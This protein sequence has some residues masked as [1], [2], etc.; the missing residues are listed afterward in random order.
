MNDTNE[1]RTSELSDLAT[2]LGFLAL[3]FT[4]LE[5]IM[6][7]FFGYL[8]RLSARESLAIGGDL[9]SAARVSLLRKSVELWEGDIDTKRH[10][11][12]FIDEYERLKKLRN[13]YIHGLWYTPTTDSAKHKHMNIKFK[14]RDKVTADIEQCSISYLLDIARDILD[15]QTNIEN[16]FNTNTELPNWEKISRNAPMLAFS[17]AAL[18]NKQRKPN[19]PAN[20]NQDAKVEPRKRQP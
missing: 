11:E 5:W 20:H 1:K 3:F 9:T 12:E 16:Y 18:R 15:L 7:D 14:A 10:F 17:Y 4:D 6:D 19:L 8:F 2:A 13:T